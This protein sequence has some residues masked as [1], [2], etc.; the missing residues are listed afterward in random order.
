MTELYLTD[1]RWA[2]IASRVPG[3]EGDPGCRGRDNRLFIESVLWIVRTGAPW[4]NLPPHFGKWYTA[5]TRFRR[6]GKKHVWSEIFALLAQDDACEYFF[7]DGVIRHAPLRA[8]AAKEAAVSL[9]AAAS[10]Q[11]EERAA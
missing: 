11:R 2:L 4:R 6:W 7:E 10:E 1:E 9:P 5:Y 3:K 8:V